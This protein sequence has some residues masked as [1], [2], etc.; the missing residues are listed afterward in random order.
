MEKPFKIPLRQ[1]CSLPL[2][3]PQLHP[4]A[5]APSHGGQ[6]PGCTAG[7]GAR[8]RVTAVTAQG[9][10]KLEKPFPLLNELVPSFFPL[11]DEAHQLALTC[12]ECS[13]AMILGPVIADI[14]PDLL[15]SVLSQAARLRS[16]SHLVRV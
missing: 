9:K 8:S 5:L 14:F 13:A 2:A 3:P 7:D 6:G 4:H 1:G 10:S 15:A 12:R 16:C 11:A